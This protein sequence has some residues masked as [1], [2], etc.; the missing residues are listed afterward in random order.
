M[1]RGPKALL[2]AAA[3]LLALPGA[4]AG[5][6]TTE[7]VLGALLEAQVAYEGGPPRSCAAWAESPAAFMAAEDPDTGAALTCRDLTEEPS[8]GAGPG[9]Y[10]LWPTGGEVVLYGPDGEVARAAEGEGGALALGAAFG[11]F[12]G[13]LAADW[14]RGN[15]GAPDW[16][17]LRRH[18]GDALVGA[19]SHPLWDGPLGDRTLG[20][21][22]SVAVRRLASH[23]PGWVVDADAGWVYEITLRDGAWRL[24]P[25]PISAP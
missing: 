11:Y 16:T 24:A 15:P 13:S 21:S 2:G 7:A 6:A 12:L 4:A 3:A 25:H 8:S 9:R 23:R 18:G 19:A 14:R 17:D 22:L 10:A 5:P 20:G 1:G